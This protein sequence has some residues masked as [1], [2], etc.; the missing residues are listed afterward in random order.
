MRAVLYIVFARCEMG[1]AV[2]QAYTTQR[3]ATTHMN[4]VDQ[5]EAD[6]ANASLRGCCSR[7]FAVNVV[8]LTKDGP[9]IV[10]ERDMVKRR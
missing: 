10:A 9:E 1:D 6:K 8:K 4:K 3:E 2:I 7:L 5:S